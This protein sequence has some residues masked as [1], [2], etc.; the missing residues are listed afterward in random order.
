MSSKSDVIKEAFSFEN[1]DERTQFEAEMIHLDVMNELQELMRIHNMN[2]SEL[3]KRLM[4]SKGYI[5]QLFSG[6]KLI[7]LKSIA[8]L[9]QIFNVKLKLQFIDQGPSQSTDNLFNK[10]KHKLRMGSRSSVLL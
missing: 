1:D 7:N 8:K 6:D 9:Q 2:K 10:R 3:A 4:T 5:T